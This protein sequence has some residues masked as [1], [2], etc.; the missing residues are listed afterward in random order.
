MYKIVIIVILLLIIVISTECKRHSSN[1]T[2]TSLLE[3]RIDSAS[4]SNKI[5][6]SKS[7]FYLVDKFMDNQNS[8][9]LFNEFTCKNIDSDLNFYSDYYI[10]Y[11]KKSKITNSQH[12][13]SFPRD[14]DRYTLQND[15]LYIYRW[16]YG[17]FI[18]K[19]KF[20]LS[21][22]PV[23]VVDTLSCY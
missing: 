14:F 3:S 2:F 8:D 21:S 6:W 13:N 4:V 10:Y 18:S 5:Y 22:N 23:S 9:R 16:S 7:V 12:L 20:N 11:F 17:V 15:L 19:E 1:V